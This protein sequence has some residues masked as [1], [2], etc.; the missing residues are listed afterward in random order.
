[1][2]YKL[3]F[4]NFATCNL[5]LFLLLFSEKKVVA[6]KSLYYVFLVILFLPLSLF[7][8]PSKKCVYI[9][10]YH[11]GFV[12]SDTISKYLKKEL[13]DTCEIIQFNMDT[14]RN[15]NIKFI[16]K[17]ALE[18]KA[19]IDKENPDI[20]IT[21]DDN[22]AK[23]LIKPY[24]KDSKIPFVFNG[25]NWSAK[26]YG[27]PYSNVTG[28]IEVTPINE[29]F[30]IAKYITNGKKGI[31]IGDD[32]ITDKKDLKQFMRFAKK[33]N[34]H[35]DNALLNTL[36]E[37]KQTYKQAQENY[38]FI[39]LGHNSAIKGWDD[40]EVNAFLLNNSKKLVLTTYSWMVQ[41]ATI[42]LTIRPEEQ[43]TWAGNTAK[44]ILNGYPIKNIA[45]TTNHIW[46]KSINMHLVNASNVKI[47]KDIVFNYKK[48]NKK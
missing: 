8:S 47:P 15:K 22:A 17:K 10:S 24:Y 38:D 16:Q 42:G 43:G 27:F 12:W 39:I 29:L 11:I 26:E 36:D 33:R 19:L 34:I 40:N 35:L 14:K 5:S 4:Y 48:F 3:L 18:A 37:W 6:M 25:I 9:N 46:N 2:F 30:K 41:F 13:K 20:V 31:F 1:M 23:Y 7:S 32:T 44:A 21:S 28:M 45:I